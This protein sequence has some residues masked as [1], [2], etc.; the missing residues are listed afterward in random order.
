[1]HKSIDQHAKHFGVLQKRGD[2]AKLHPR[3]WP[4]GH[5]ADVLA[6][7]VAGVH[8]DCSFERVELGDAQARVMVCT[9]W[10]ASCMSIEHR[11]H[12]LHERIHVACQ[13]FGRDNAA[14]KLLAVS[15]TFSADAVRQAHAQGLRDFGEN[16]IQEGVEKIQA[17]SDLD[18]TWHCIGP[19]QSNKTRLVAA[20][21]DWVHSVDRIKTAERL[22]DQRS[23]GQLPLQ[24]CLQ[25]NTDGGPSKSGVSPEDLM[26]LAKA[27]MQLPRVQ[28]RGLMTIP[29]PVEG[30]EAQI[31][32]HKR[33][34]K[35]FDQVKK[36]INP[37]QWDTLSMGMSADLESAIAAG[38]TLLRVGTALFGQR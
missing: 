20:H 37:P 31:D 33:A 34:K 22:S 4:I 27:V 16:Y 19:V 25:V 26:A 24:L 7:V 2:V 1:M 36:E 18:M 15:K 17:L 11:L 30:F 21:F 29:D 14:V 9:I 6:Q 8:E 32:L 23:E 3:R 5:G 10:Y 12:I 38:S 28:L 35:L 13:N